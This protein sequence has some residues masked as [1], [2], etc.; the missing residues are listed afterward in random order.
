MA[1]MRFRGDTLDDLGKLAELIH[2]LTGQK[3]SV[4]LLVRAAVYEMLDRVDPICFQND[5]ADL[6]GDA[7]KAGEAHNRWLRSLAAIARGRDVTV[8]VPR[9]SEPNQERNQIARSEP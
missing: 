3:P 6:G 7:K 5:I 8:C 4:N 2:R 9:G 1:G